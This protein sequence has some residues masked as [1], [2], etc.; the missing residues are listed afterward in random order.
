MFLSFEGLRQN[1]ENAVPLLTNTNSFLP[2]PAQNAV[3]DGLLPSRHPVP[4]LNNPN[5]TVTHPAG[6]SVRRLHSQLA[7]TTSQLTGLPGTG[8]TAINTYLDQPAGIQRRPV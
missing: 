5:G 2:T 7:L 4:C 8:Q 6:P 1:S 3:I